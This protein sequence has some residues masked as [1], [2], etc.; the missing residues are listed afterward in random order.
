MLTGHGH[1]MWSA[2]S[3]SLGRA[4]QR[5]DPTGLLYPPITHHGCLSITLHIPGAWLRLKST[6]IHTVLPNFMRRRHLGFALRRSPAG[7]GKQDTS[8]GHVSWTVSTPGGA[9][10][11]VGAGLANLA[12]PRLQLGSIAVQSILAS[13]FRRQL[14]PTSIRTSAPT[15]YSGNDCPILRP[16][17]KSWH[18]IPGEDLR[19]CARRGRIGPPTTNGR[20]YR[21][22]D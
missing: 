12:G 21:V 6:L 19:T 11:L 4:V 2:S 1:D 17:L 8:P 15:S 18:G 7:S 16:R 5:S 10:T 13:M 20:P 22:L 9:N 14:Y 3:Q